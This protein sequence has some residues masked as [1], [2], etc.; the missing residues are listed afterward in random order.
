MAAR[1]WRRRL[2]WVGAG[3]ALLAAVSWGGGALRWQARTAALHRGLDGVRD[4]QPATTYDERELADLP[5]VVQRY[6]RAVLRPG[7]PMVLAAR[8]AQR[9][10]IN[11]ADRGE[12]WQPFSAVHH[13]ATSPP[14]FVW[15]AVVTMAGFVPLRVHDAYVRHGGV[16][17]AALFGLLPLASQRG[18]GA[19]AMAQLVRYLA[20]A[21]WYPTALLPSQGVHWRAVDDRRAEATLVDGDTSVT[22]TFTFADGGHIAAVQVTARGRTVGD[23]LVPTPW[24]GRFA[25]P[26]RC[27]GMLVP[28]CAE[29]FWQLPAGE[30]VYWRGEVERIDYEWWR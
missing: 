25:E 27:D 17:D 12:S 8:L 30:H 28:R 3:V 2:A 22:A 11:L 16:T 20:E 24:G 5:P 6:F 7:Q 13:V 1:P 10:T 18:T 21:P 15:D 26:V 9:G 29:V 19:A 14:G 23:T 4:H